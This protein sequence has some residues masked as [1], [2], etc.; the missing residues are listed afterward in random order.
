[1]SRA[2]IAGPRDKLPQSIEVL[3]ELRLIHIVD[4]HG[5]DDTFRIGKPL[6]PAAEL[7]DNLVKLLSLIH[8]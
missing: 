5:E 7:S 3:H 1:M 6:S 2:V 4:H 8:I